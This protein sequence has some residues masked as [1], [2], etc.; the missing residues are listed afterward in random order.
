VN[1]QAL[2]SFDIKIG[3]DYEAGEFFWQV[4]TSG[5]LV[6]AGQAFTYQAC[7][8]QCGRAIRQWLASPAPQAARP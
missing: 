6:A 2:P 7:T 4:R 8:H 3:P 5:V 1:H